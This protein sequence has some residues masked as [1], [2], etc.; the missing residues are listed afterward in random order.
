MDNSSDKEGLEEAMDV[1]NMESGPAE[2][3]GE[4][5]KKGQVDYA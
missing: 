2:A 1:D 4:K 3:K 5:T